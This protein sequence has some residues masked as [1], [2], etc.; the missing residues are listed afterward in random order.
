[1]GRD[2][3]FYCGRVVCAG[4][5]KLDDVTAGYVWDVCLIAAILRGVGVWRQFC[6]RCVDVGLDD[7]GYN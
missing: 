3:V 6:T 1:M 4:S 5:S 7:G 2:G